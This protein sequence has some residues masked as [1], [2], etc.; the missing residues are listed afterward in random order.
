[1]QL[2]N[3]LVTL[4]QFLMAKHPLLP[5]LLCSQTDQEFDAGLQGLLESAVDFLERN[6][7]LLHQQSEDQI[8][9]SVVAY[10]NLPGLRVTQ[11]THTNGHVDITIEAELP[12]RRRLGEAKIYSG[13]QYHVDGMDQLFNRYMTG[14]E[15]LG[16]LLSYVKKDDI[17]G[18]VDKVRLHLDTS[19]PCQQKGN[20]QDHPIKWAFMT[21]HQHTSGEAL[22]I[23]HL[24]CNLYRP[25]VP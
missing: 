8:T 9:C 10:L 11:Q 24:N 19:K 18:L 2:D 3:S 16:I 6:A 5:K 15:G 13:P 22:P 23:L 1:M 7:G 17:K 21:H 4:A 25:S 20:S 14:R 12:L